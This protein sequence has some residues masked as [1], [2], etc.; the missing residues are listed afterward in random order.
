M[1]CDLLIRWSQVRILPGVPRHPAEFRH[2]FGKHLICLPSASVAAP[3]VALSNSARHPSARSMNRIYSPRAIH[4]AR[5][6]DE[7]ADR[8]LTVR[9][10]C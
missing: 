1:F 8:R 4:H 10:A 9:G 3:E 6:H 2:A 5:A 7:R